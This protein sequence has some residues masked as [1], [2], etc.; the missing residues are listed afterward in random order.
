MNF[1]ILQA[2]VA[3]FVL[4]DGMLLLRVLVP[5][6]CTPKIVAARAARSRTVGSES[7]MRSVMTLMPRSVKPW[8]SSRVS[9]AVSAVSRRSSQWK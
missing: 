8:S 3:A 7:S 6:A 1:N 2:V 9:C 5:V 4:A